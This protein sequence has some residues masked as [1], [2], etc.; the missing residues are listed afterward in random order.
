M[1]GFP[2]TVLVTGAGGF[3]GRAVV[4]LL[5][6]R[7]VEVRALVRKATAGTG[8][9]VVPVVGDVT[10]PETLGGAVAGCEGVIHLVGIIDEKHGTFEEIHVGGTR[11]IVA[12]AKP[13]GV[14]RYVQMSAVGTRA[15]AKARYHQT[16]WAAEEMV[17]GSGLEWTIVRPSLIVGASG[18][19][20]GEFT[21]MLKGWARGTAAPY[22]FM[23]FFGVGVLGQT[24]PYRVQ[25]VWV[26]DVA[27][28]FVEALGNQA[29]VGKTYEIG[30]PAK[31]GWKEML[32]TAAAEFRG[33]RKLILGIPAW[34]AK[35]V[36]SLPVP[37]PF[38]RDQVVMAMEDNTCDNAAAEA[39]FF[40]G[41]RL[42]GFAEVLGECAKG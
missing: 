39:A 21:E 35:L 5:R 41:R 34:Y 32:G 42:R 33:R 16:K 27:R 36:A 4:G 31:M 29:A 18:G 23:P 25:P 1:D 8:A 40:G 19:R 13:A 12:A 11:N 10:R 28:V 6:E 17:R 3:V 24:N 37:V 30:G 2:R 22:V 20:V 15:G 26:G 38:S 7:G 14:R 9:G